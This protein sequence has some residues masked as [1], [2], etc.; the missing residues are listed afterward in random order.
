MEAACSIK[1]IKRDGYERLL[2]KDA[3]CGDFTVLSTD[4]VNVI[5]NTKFEAAPGPW[6]K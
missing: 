4:E 3:A 2:V 6:Y 5:L 1:F